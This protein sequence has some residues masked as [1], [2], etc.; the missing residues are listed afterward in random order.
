MKRMMMTMMMTTTMTMKRKN[1][2]LRINQYIVVEGNSLVVVEVLVGK[3]F[4]HH[5]YKIMR[6]IRENRI[7]QM[8]MSNHHQLN[9]VH[10]RS[11]E[12]QENSLVVVNT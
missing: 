4:D 3:D 11:V 8:T 12:D 7:H 9:I 2:Q 1:Q 5:L 6:R 10:N